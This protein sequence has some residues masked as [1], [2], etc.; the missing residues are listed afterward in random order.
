MTGSL[1]VEQDLIK[2]K[3]NNYLELPSSDHN[4]D[5]D[6]SS[7]YPVN[8]TMGV[9]QRD[10]VLGDPLSGQNSNMGYYRHTESTPQSVQENSE[11]LITV[12]ADT[13]GKCVRGDVNVLHSS[14]NNLASVGSSGIVH[15]VGNL[16]GYVQHNISSSMVSEAT[17]LCIDQE[18]STQFSVNST[19][20]VEELPTKAS[21]VVVF[22]FGIPSASM[23]QEEPSP[24]MVLATED[25]TKD[26]I[27]F[28]FGSSH[29]E[30]SDNGAL[31]REE[32][33][34]SSELAS[35]AQLVGTLCSNRVNGTKYQATTCTTG[36]VV[37]ITEET[38]DSN[39]FFDF[40]K[41]TKSGKSDL[42]TFNKT[43]GDEL[44]END[45]LSPLLLGEFYLSQTSSAPDAGL[46]PVSKDVL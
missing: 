6:Y 19:P 34:L 18:A 5:A 8:T 22:D 17:P 45:Q 12:D 13:Q 16:D 46:S 39:D 4:M 36:Y 7:P 11:L 37:G 41:S 24:N 15:S 29:L 14:V 35:H 2:E 20:D 25:D 10:S 44:N 38:R 28:D 23:S 43:L 32:Q 31:L 42:Y 40:C 33:N 9:T 21:P 30:L 27:A 1:W 26:V 3:L